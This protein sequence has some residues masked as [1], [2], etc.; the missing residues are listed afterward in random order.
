MSRVMY[1]AAAV[2]VLGTAGAGMALAQDKPQDPIVAR[3]NLM[4]DQGNDLYRVI[5]GMT[6]GRVPYDAA[7]ASAAFA[8]IAADSTHIAALFPDDSKTGHDTHALPK[9]WQNKTDFEAKAQK[10]H[11]LALAAADSSKQ[12]LDATK[13]AFKAVDDACDA[14]HDDYRAPYKKR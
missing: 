12:G 10:V 5:L 14:C 13:A 4:K 7:K 3:Q 6:R 9:I 8:S 2:A 1:V 11:E